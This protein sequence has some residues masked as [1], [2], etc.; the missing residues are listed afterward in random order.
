MAS[1]NGSNPNTLNAV[2][3][4]NRNMG[5]L[6]R[7]VRLATNT[8]GDI[9]GGIGNTASNKDVELAVRW[10]IAIAN[11]DT[12]GYSQSVRWGP[13]YDCSS[14]ITQA[15]RNFGFNIGGGTGV[16]TGNMIEYF[17]AAGFTWHPA[18]GDRSLPAS[19]LL[20]GDIML[21]IAMHTQMYIGNNQDVS[22]AGTKQ[23]IIVTSHNDYY[24]YR[25]Y[26]GWDGFLRY[27]G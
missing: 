18:T 5:I 20:R 23:G 9:L 14:F 1:F 19:I 4:L 11:D 22:A 3:R 25:G 8:I 13:S 15:F 26:N 24:S 6:E 2:N 17:T 27:E 7:V 10:C 16:Y 12:H 21:N